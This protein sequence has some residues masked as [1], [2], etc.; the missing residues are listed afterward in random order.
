LFSSSAM[1]FSSLLTVLLR[2][3]TTVSAIGAIAP[4]CEEKF[5]GEL[6]RAMRRTR[7]CAGRWE[8][9]R[10]KCAMAGRVVDEVE[11]TVVR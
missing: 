10:D 2:S 9:R 11:L 3:S 5:W 1:R 4:K 8:W 6:Q 7:R